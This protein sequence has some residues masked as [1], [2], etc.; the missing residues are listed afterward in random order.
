VATPNFYV[1]QMYAAHQGAQAVRAEFSAPDV[2]YMRDAKPAR[3]WGL[4]GS[5]S[6]KGNAVTLTVVNPSAD[7]PRQAEVVLR[8]GRASSAVADVLTSTD[9]HAHNTF[10]HQAITE[11]TT[12][13]VN[14]SGAGL[15]FTFPPA[16][17]TKLSITLS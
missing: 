17:I 15:A 6:R 11:P 5:A 14:I 8:G 4:R 16:S 3:F 9:L 1:F 13:P 10:E 7:A 2:S 12:E